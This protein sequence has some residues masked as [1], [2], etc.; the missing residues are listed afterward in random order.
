MEGDLLNPLNKLVR[1]ETKNRV[2]HRLNNLYPHLTTLQRK[3]LKLTSEGLSPIEVADELNIEHSNIYAY[4]DGISKRLRKK[5]IPINDF[6]ELL[7]SEEEHV[8]SPM[9]RSEMF[10]FERFRK[11][12]FRLRQYFHDC[13]GND[14]TVFPKY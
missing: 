2:K 1:D 3:I 10:L 12:L 7:R 11:N 8:F 5:K 4:I 14:Q 6:R 13:F 9:A